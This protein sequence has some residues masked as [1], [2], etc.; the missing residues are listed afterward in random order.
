MDKAWGNCIK[1][2]LIQEASEIHPALRGDLACRGVW[3]VQREA[4]FDI[5]VT[6]T[7]APSYLSRTVS[8]V[9]KTAE[10]EKKRKYVSACE[11]RHA[12]FTPLVASVD[13]HFA[14]QMSA[15]VKVLA[16]RL[17]DKWGQPQQITRSWIRTR[18]AFAILRASSLCIHSSRKRWRCAEDLLGGADGAA[19]RA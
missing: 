18:L 5:R 7:D 2:P 17:A 12:T 19:L 9:F 4:L 11:A 14:P 8:T 10:E 1:E 16:E 13:G 6:D 15:F 3:E